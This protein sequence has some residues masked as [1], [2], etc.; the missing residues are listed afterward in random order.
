MA[1]RETDDEIANAVRAYLTEH[2]QAMDTVEGIAHW[3]LMRQHV[4]VQVEA[5][6]RVLHAMAEAGVLDE[7]GT[8]D[9]RRY[10]LR[11]H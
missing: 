11:R 4:R 3:W 10:R 8:G 9:Q 6:S 5:L 7:L 1:D 2:P